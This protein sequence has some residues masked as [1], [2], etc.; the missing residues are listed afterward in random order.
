MENSLGEYEAILG[1]IKAQG[2]EKAR[3]GK[4]VQ[5]AGFAG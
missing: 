2:G 5:G 3:L 4:G 1:R